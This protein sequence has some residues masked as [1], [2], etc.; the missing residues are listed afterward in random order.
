MPRLDDQPLDRQMPYLPSPR[1]PI[2]PPQEPQIPKP[3]LDL[4]ILT[5]GVVPIGV[6]CTED[7]EKGPAVT[8]R[9][10]VCYTLSFM[11]LVVSRH[12]HE[13]PGHEKR[14]KNSSCLGLCIHDAILC[15]RSL[16]LFSISEIQNV[17]DMSFSSPT[18]NSAPSATKP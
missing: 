6:S 9:G 4:G 3:R 1:L 14:R 2:S 18:F 7:G 15:K 13:V 16:H 11:S 8:V 12:L 17:I 10:H 5:A